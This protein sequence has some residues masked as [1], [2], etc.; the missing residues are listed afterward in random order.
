MLISAFRADDGFI[1]A[2]KNQQL[3]TIVTFFTLIFV[4]R[5]KKT[6]LFIEVQRFRVQRFKVHKNNP[7]PMND[8]LYFIKYKDKIFFILA[9]TFFDSAFL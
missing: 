8:C 4:Y 7:E 1:V 3:K 5:H 9:G 6:P 2:A